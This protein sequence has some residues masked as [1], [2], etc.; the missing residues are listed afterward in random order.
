M[1]LRKYYWFHFES[2]ETGTGETTNE[3]TATEFLELLNKWNSMSRR[4]QYWAEPGE[5]I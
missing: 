5:T 2:R 4:W 3:V 1:R